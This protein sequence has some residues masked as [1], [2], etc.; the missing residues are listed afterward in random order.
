[1]N[2]TTINIHKNKCCKIVLDEGTID[3]LANHQICIRDG[4]TYIDGI[5]LNEYVKT[6]KQWNKSID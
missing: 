4:I 2:Q 6:K 1:M 3:V 5:P